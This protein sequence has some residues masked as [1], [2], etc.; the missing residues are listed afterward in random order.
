MNL[1]DEEIYQKAQE[2]VQLIKSM[3]G[4]LYDELVEILFQYD[5]MGITS[6]DHVSAYVPEV[7][8][9]LPKLKEA[10]EV[11]ALQNILYEVCIDQF[12]IMNKPV[13]K[14]NLSERS[15]QKLDAAAQEIWKLW[16]A[17]RIEHD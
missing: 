3:Y 14:H 7:L 5:P 9:I 16:E 1:E 11:Y 15:K 4:K 10:H 8:D 12:S 6:G 2:K 17:W 13:P